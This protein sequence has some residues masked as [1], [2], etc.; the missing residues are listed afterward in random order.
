MKL[1][2]DPWFRN[3]L[4]RDGIYKAIHEQMVL[5]PEIHILGEGAVMKI[6]FDAPDIE[7]DF[8]NRV[9]TMPICFP[10]DTLLPGANKQ[11]SLVKKGDVVYGASGGETTIKNVMSREYSGNLVVLRPRYLEDIICTPEHPLAI[12]TRSKLKFDC[13]VYRPEHSREIGYEWMGAGDVSVGDFVVVPKLRKKLQSSSMDLRHYAKRLYDNRLQ[14]L[15]FPIDEETAWLLG[16]YVAEGSTNKSDRNFVI[17]FSLH[18]KEIDIVNRIKKIGERFGYSVRD[19]PK[20]DGDNGVEVHFGCATLGW[21]LIEWCGDGARNKRIPEFIMTAD[22]SLR[23]SFLRGLFDGDGWKQGDGGRFKIQ[24]TTSSR[25]LVQQVQLLMTS[26]GCLPGIWHRDPA[27]STLKSGRV[28]HQGESWILGSSSPDAA[29]IFGM[30]REGREMWSYVDVGDYVLTPVT[31]KKA[32]W[33]DGLVYNI[34][35]GENTYLVSNALVHNCEDGSSNFAVGLSLAGIVPIVDVI[36]SDFLYRTMDS[37]CNTMAKAAVVGDAR[38]MIVRAEFL[39]GGPTSG[40]RIESLFAHIPGLRV[41][42]PSNPEDAY[43]L[44]L[45][46]LETPAITIFFEDRMIEDAKMPAKRQWFMKDGTRVDKGW[47]ARRSQF[48]GF[49]IVVSYGI[50]LRRA[51]EALRGNEATVIDLRTLYPLDVNKV[52]ESLREAHLQTIPRPCLLVVEPD[53]QFL[54]IGAEL[55]AQVVELMPGV[56]V[57]RLGGPRATIPASRELHD[58]MIP[59]EE[60]IFAVVKSMQWNQT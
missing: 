7:R 43:D 60:D 11:I 56:V 49:P 42:I 36:S 10:G 6:K 57:R 55:I 52:V 24:L 14:L 26:L 22:D 32:K 58:R 46:A 51:E 40:Q 44:M 16:I 45:E 48:G 17:N 3:R 2:R 37:I 31:E 4:I 25:V 28:I 1:V 35:T 54:G 41:V 8:S 15:D 38:T 21:A 34:E 59:T 20:A 19:Y 23:T 50:T 5:R 33:Y 39:T 9:I 47:G 27:E 29:T 53:V 12:V 13:G 18:A 30:Q